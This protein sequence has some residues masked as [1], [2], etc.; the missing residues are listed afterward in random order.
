MRTSKALAIKKNIS[1][2]SG[3]LQANS[4]SPS[5]SDD[6]SVVDVGGEGDCWLLTV[7]ASLLSSQFTPKAMPQPRTN[8]RVLKIVVLGDSGYVLPKK[9]SESPHARD[10]C[11]HTLD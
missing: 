6:S 8:K 2:G 4:S 1:L 10:L 5:C 7:F 3:Y 11:A 9:R